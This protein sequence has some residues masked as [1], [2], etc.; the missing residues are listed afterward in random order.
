MLVL[1]AVLA[2]K[3]CCPELWV[4]SECDQMFHP[5]EMKQY[6]NISGMLPLPLAPM[7]VC[8]GWYKHNGPGCDC[9]VVE[10][11]KVYKVC[12][13]LG[14]YTQNPV[15]LIFLRGWP[16]ILIGQIFQNMDKYGSFGF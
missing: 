9:L 5:L 8:K 7:R 16:S 14:I 4:H 12:I 2:V 3:L 11:P 6:Q 1:T 13:Y 10:R 15:D